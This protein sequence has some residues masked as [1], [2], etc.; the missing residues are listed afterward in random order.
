MADARRMNRMHPPRALALAALALCGG[1]AF[2]ST[3]THWNGHLGADG[4]PVF[5]LTSSYVGMNLGVVLPMAGRTSID[6]MIDEA[7]RR[8][9]A[10][11]GDH[12]RLVETETNNYWY[13]LPP[14]S[15]LFSPVVTSISFEYRP[16]EAA[17]AAVKAADAARAE[18][19][20]ASPVPP[21]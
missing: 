8:I 11:E 1:C 4:Q 2:H 7:T 9:T 20:P 13:G 6:E 12:L 5:V 3:A 14:L 21:R 19:N 15:W 10:V 17:V 18:Q 16:S